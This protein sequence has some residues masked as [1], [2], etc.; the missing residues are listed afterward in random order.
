MRPQANCATFRADTKLQSIQRSN[1]A[2]G[3]ES[4]TSHAKQVFS[5]ALPKDFPSLRCH[6]NRQRGTRMARSGFARTHHKHA[7]KI[8]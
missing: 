3:H 7:I 4:S 2:L 8:V 6:K 1:F 5:S